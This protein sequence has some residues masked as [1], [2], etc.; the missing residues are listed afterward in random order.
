MQV[1]YSSLVF[2]GKAMSLPQNGA[3]EYVDSGLT[4][5]H[6]SMLEMLARG[7][8]SSLLRTHVNYSR[9]TFC[10]IGPWSGAVL[11]II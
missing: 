9:K 3:P 5:K 1:F 4:H 8:N 6:L 11:G 10:N 2:V 7:K